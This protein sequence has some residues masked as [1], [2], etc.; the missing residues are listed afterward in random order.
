ME[1]TVRVALVPFKQVLRVVGSARLVS[2]SVEEACDAVDGESALVPLK[3]ML[4]SVG[5]SFVFCRLICHTS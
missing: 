2:K 5:Y 3:Q 4:R 1:L